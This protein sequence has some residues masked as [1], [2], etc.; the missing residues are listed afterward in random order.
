MTSRILLL[1]IIA[2]TAS[3]L[4]AEI[5]QWE[6]DQGNTH[7]SDE[8]PPDARSDSRKV[9]PDTS[10]VDTDSEAVQQRKAK[11]REYLEDRRQEREQQAREKAAAEEEQARQQARC[12]EMEGRLKHME[13]VSRFYVIND[14]GSRSYVSEEEAQRVRERRQ[15][16]Y[17][18]ACQ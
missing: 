7:F 4:A 10:A 11:Q 8:P 5:Y 12:R 16:Q 15:K 9:E 13:R 1:V 17:E 18:Q 14:D 3:P 6:D 2:V